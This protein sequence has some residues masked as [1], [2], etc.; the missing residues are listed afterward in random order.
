MPLPPPTPEAIALAR[1][2]YVEGVAVAAILGECAMSLGTLYKCVDGWPESGSPRLPA[3]PRRRIVTGKRRRA[4]RGQRVSLVARLWR[5]A[6]RQV[7][8]IEDR[9]ARSQQLPDERERDARVLS[10]L[11]KT[12]R[13][14]TAL[15]AAK[16]GANSQSEASPADDDIPR[17]IDELRR[18]LSRRVDILRQRR[19][20]AGT[21]GDAD[22]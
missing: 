17:D 22:T 16:T 7:R 1:Q 2:R 14:L 13:E 12:L 10:V 20:A 4:L 21:V 15:D 8:D 11:V 5:T 18:E 6:E 19:A 9:L 3:L